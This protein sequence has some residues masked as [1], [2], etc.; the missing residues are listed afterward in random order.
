MLVV[1]L[2]VCFC[3]SGG[4]EGRVL[5]MHPQDYHLIPSRRLLDQQ[6][7]FDFIS[8]SLRT[9]S[10]VAPAVQNASQLA[11]ERAKAFV[12][13]YST[14]LRVV[15]IPGGALVTFLGYYLLTPVLFGAGMLTGGGASFVALRALLGHE[16]PSA[17]WLS[18]VGSLLCGFVVA[19]LAVRLLRI[20][21]FAIGAVLGVIVA[22]ALTP[23]V[24][25][26]VY[27]P[28]HHV[29]F[30]VGA[31][32]LG[33]IFGLIALAFQKPMVILATAYGGS[34]GCFFGI[35]YFAG[36]FPDT[37]A[38]SAAEKGHFGA[39]LIAYATLTAFF[40]TAGAVVQYRLA[41]HS[42]SPAQR[43]VHQARRRRDDEWYEEAQHLSASDVEDP[44]PK[45][46]GVVRTGVGKEVVEAKSDARGVYGVDYGRELKPRYYGD[47][48]VGQVDDMATVGRSNSNEQ[49][50]Q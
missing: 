1:I 5:R 32:V 49:P 13:S 3:I 47:V 16:R 35:G 19:L 24:L 2:G 34:F 41:K 28:N 20:G 38:L 4:V 29:G 37:A 17:L 27:P 44:A 40:G 30:Y 43:R 11:L 45:D 36:H 22:S 48:S 50:N 21:M 15:A 12:T 31:V 46:L 23:T 42:P 25:G 18:A 14:A 7:D 9:V 33:I 8:A 26:R 39:W 6:Q 10:D